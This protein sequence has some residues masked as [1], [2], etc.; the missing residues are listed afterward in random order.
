MNCETNN[1]EKTYTI[2]DWL[3]GRVGLA[4]PDE[5]IASLCFSRSVEPDSACSEID[6]R[7]RDLLEADLLVHIATT[8]ANKMNNT[9]DSDNGW[10]HSEGGYTLTDDDKERMLARARS[11][12]EKWDE[13]M[14][15]DDNAKVSVTSFGIR[16]CDFDAS[17]WPL[18]HFASL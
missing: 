8:W 10:S 13:E 12:Y 6:E 11:L 14:P 17:D 16:H 4:V 15:L 7:G 1:T 9:S 5:N 2:A 18:P 3:C